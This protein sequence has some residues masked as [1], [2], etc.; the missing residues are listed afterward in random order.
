M[1]A[2]SYFNVWSMMEEM[3]LRGTFLRMAVDAEYILSMAILGIFKNNKAEI[4]TF[5][6]KDKKKGIGKD[7]HEL[8][9]WEKLEVCKRGL[10]KY[11]QHFYN[12]H[13]EDLGKLDELREHRNLFAHEK[14]DFFYED[15]DKIQFSDL[16]NKYKV[17]QVPTSIKQLWG[18][19]NEYNKTVYQVLHLLQPY[20][21]FPLPLTHST[22]EKP[23]IFDSSMP[24]HYRY[25][26]QSR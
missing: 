11:N 1:T 15:R 10:N 19:L 17:K 26:P 7:L 2:E 25:Y 18:W 5:F 6:L 23:Q 12:L 14:F 4:K 21:D 3:K 22:K 24:Y 20:V 16:V 9:M 13:K 8:D